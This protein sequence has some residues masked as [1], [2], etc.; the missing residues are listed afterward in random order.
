MCG[1]TK[2]MSQSHVP[3]RCAGNKDIVARHHLVRIRGNEI[4]PGRQLAGGIHLYGLCAKC[5]KR[6]G[7]FDSAYRDL[8]EPLRGMW[9]KYWQ[10][11]LPPLL[12]TPSVAF[13]PGSVA[14]SILLG[15]CATGPLIRRHWPELPT[16]L[17]DG[18]P[19]ELPTEMRLYLALARGLTARVAG[20]IVGYHAAGPHYRLDSRGVPVGR[21]SISSVYFPPLAWEL[22]HAM[23]TTLPAEGWVDVSDWTT[24]QP[25]ATHIL[26]DLVPALPAVCHPKHHPTLHEHWLE[27]L[28]TE[29]APIVECANVE[30]GSPD[31][32]APA[33]QTRICVSPDYF[34][35]LARQRGQA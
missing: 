9:A 10:I 3:P 14:R 27:M 33:L 32:R 7:R 23:E 13:D 25:G 22:V 11:E 1:F 28:D 31:P 6:A 4:E 29:L 34:K 21:S 8:V 18:D 20:P 30:G 12:R 19:V 26:S 15:M 24:V 35:D 17:A 16:R 2:F 5:N